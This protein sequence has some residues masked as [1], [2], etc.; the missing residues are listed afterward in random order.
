MFTQCNKQ[1]TEMILLV[2]NFKYIKLQSVRGT[3]I[4]RYL[5]ITFTGFFVLKKVNF[6]KLRLVILYTWLFLPRVIFA[7][8]CLQIDS[9]RLEYAHMQ[10]CERR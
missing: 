8:Q 3:P 10:L 2:L 7:L 1:D 9:S 4:F 5:F 6:E